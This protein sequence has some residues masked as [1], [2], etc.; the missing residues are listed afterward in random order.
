MSLFF[1]EKI[2]IKIIKKSHEFLP[3]NILEKKVG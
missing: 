3:R 1:Q 2:I